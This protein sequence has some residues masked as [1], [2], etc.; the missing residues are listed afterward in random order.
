MKKQTLLKLA[1]VLVSLAAA[2][3]GTGQRPLAVAGR[4]EIVPPVRYRVIDLG[5]DSFGNVITDSGRIL[6]SISFG[7]PDRDA[8]F[9][10]SP[11]SSA[12][13]LGTLPG[14]TGSRGLG[15]NSRGQMVGFATP[16]DMQ[17]P[18]FW[19]GSQSAPVE[20]P[21]LSDG[22]VGQASGINR[23]GQIVGTFFTA[24]SELP[25]FWPNSNASPTYLTE[26]SNELPFGE[27]LSINA[28]GNIFGDGCSPDFVECHAAF[29]EN[30]ASTP[31]ALASP[32]GDFIYT[33]AGGFSSGETVAHGLNNSGSMA[34]FAYN[35]DF[36]QTRAVFWASN[37]SPAV[38]LSTSDEFSNGT[39]ECIN[40]EGRIVG[41]AYNSDFS[42]SH[43]FLWQS[44]NSPGID[45]NTVISPH[46]GW[47]LE[48]ARS[49]NRAGA[50]TGEGL[51]N[52][53]GHGYALI[54]VR[55][56][57]N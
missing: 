49:V 24:D 3:V 39:A 57:D 26:L 23:C 51:L 18:L 22:I 48:I 33:D 14:F 28:A 37:S 17:A 36:S 45:L 15:M 1:F 32:G 6:G 29:W 10:P 34:G 56:S 44:A 40:D 50:I 41:T 31:V 4:P 19:A 43:A 38:V 9:F 20:L 53:V 55:G 27:A 8:G 25:V 11:R 42:E 12:I 46:S 21:G 5:E 35:A 52:G 47:V 2:T 7:G 16:F 54:P 30:S 13:D